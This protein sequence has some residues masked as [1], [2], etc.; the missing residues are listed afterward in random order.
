MSVQDTPKEGFYQSLWKR[1]PPVN[2]HGW[3]GAPFDSL[4]IQNEPTGERKATIALGTDRAQS[5]EVESERD[6]LLLELVELCLHTTSEYDNII[7]IYS[8]Y[9]PICLPVRADTIQR[10]K[11]CYASAGLYR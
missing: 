2:E 9:Q 8:Q 6:T 5:L 1:T 3:C 11:K 4:E 10:Y 7:Y